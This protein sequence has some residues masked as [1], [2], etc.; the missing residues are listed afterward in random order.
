[1]SVVA[2]C[3]ELRLCSS[4]LAR[5][6]VARF[7]SPHDAPH[8][9]CDAMLRLVLADVVDWCR[10]FIVDTSP[11]DVI[12]AAARHRRRRASLRHAAQIGSGSTALNR[13]HRLLSPHHYSS[14]WHISSDRCRDCSLVSIISL[15]SFVVA[16]YS[17]T[18]SACCE[19]IIFFFC[20]LV[21]FRFLSLC[22]RQYCTL[23]FIS[24]ESLFIV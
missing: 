21:F 23:E 12:D 24:I 13:Q 17:R 7:L 19:T 2:I 11:I 22:S 6:I 15:Q 18:S 3:G 9:R 16:R 8:A 5:K 10:T 20:C 14:I 4:V 1:M